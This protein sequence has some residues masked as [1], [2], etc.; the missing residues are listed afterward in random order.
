MRLRKDLL[1]LQGLIEGRIPNRKMIQD[2]DKKT[3][4]N[5]EFLES[6]LDELS[7]Y[8]SKTSPL[9]RHLKL[10]DIFNEAYDYKIKKDNIR[11]QKID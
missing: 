7:V 9:C 11:K 3:K 4:E 10:D 5:P 1:Y 2:Y 8:K 6:L